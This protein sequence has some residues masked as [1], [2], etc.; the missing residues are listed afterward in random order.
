MGEAAR[1][2]R[3]G[4]QRLISA[5]LDCEKPVVA[6]VNATR[7]GGGMHLALA[8]D[9]VLAAEEAKFIEV[10]VRRGSPPTPVAPISCP[11]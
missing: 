1:L 4:W 10:F 11:G 6:A 8:C 9:L 2:I 3:T 7:P 5:V